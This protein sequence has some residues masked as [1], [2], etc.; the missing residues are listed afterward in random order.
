MNNLYPS[1]IRVLLKSLLP[2][3]RVFLCITSGAD[4]GEP[5]VDGVASHP[6]SLAYEIYNRCFSSN[7]IGKGSF[8]ATRPWTP[9]R[10]PMI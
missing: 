7:A 1:L 9:I 2:P 6:P 5:W 10:G 3:P 4:Q 8:T